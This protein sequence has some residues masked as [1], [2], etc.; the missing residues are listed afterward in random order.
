MWSEGFWHV[1]PKS[2]H[3]KFVETASRI[4]S[5]SKFEETVLGVKLDD[6]LYQIFLMENRRESLRK[7]LLETYFSPQLQQV[8]LQQGAVN[9][10]VFEYSQELLQTVKANKPLR[11][12]KEE[13]AV[14][15]QGF[16]TAVR[17]AYD[18]HCAM[19]GLRIVTIEGHSAVVAAHIIPWSETHNDDPRNGIALSHTCHWAFDEGLLTITHDYRIKLSPQLNTA[20]NAPKHLL[21]LEKQPIIA[22]LDEALWPSRESLKWH[23]SERFRLR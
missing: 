14:R 16:R 1:L 22:P 10:K 9:V 21:K 6:E 15:D 20:M 11:E 13:Y 3:E 18:H 19:T 7:V 4:E 23:R 8:L 5:I 2:G 12:S 17:Q